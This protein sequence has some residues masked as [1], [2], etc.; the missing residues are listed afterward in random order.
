MGFLSWLLGRKPPP[1]EGEE[2]PPP[3]PRPISIEWEDSQGRRIVHET[4]MIVAEDGKMLAR[5]RQRPPSELVQLR[6]NGSPYPVEILEVRTLTDGVELRMDYLWEGRRREKR[7]PAEGSALLER[8]GLP[9]LEVEVVNVSSGGMQLFSTVE[10]K[11]GLSA[12]IMGTDLERL[13]LVRYCTR[14]VGGYR[15]GLQ[16]FGDD[17][18]ERK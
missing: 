14:V 3:A 8:D 6:E 15:V 17:R 1:P 10:L 11:E 7:M 9:P 12:R 18:S 5:I 4:V 16:F 13:S 2:I